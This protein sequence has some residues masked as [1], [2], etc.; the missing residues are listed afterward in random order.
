MVYA[1]VLHVDGETETAVRDVWARLAELGLARVAR[2]EDVA[3]HL[4]LWVTDSL[5]EKLVPNAL[6]H[7]C[8]QR[9]SLEA[10]FRSVGAFPGRFGPVFFAPVPS[11]ELLTLHHDAFT[12]AMDLGAMPM[13]HQR[14]SHWVPHLTASLE[15][16]EGALSEAI[17]VC[18]EA[19]MPEVSTLTGLGLHRTLPN[20]EEIHR[21]GFSARY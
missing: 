21:V 20:V 7:F 19:A 6:D 18:S 11:S 2:S 16:K 1:L 10:R 5:G 8:E 17:A 3:P 9:P 15:L 14:P 12:L 13:W 4:T